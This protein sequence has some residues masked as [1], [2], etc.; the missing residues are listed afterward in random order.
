MDHFLGRN[1]GQ[2]QCRGVLHIVEAGDTLYKIGKKYGVPVSAIMYAN[3]YVNIYNLQIG[4]EICVPV[5]V[6][7]MPAAQA[8]ESFENYLR[9]NTQPVRDSDSRRYNIPTQEE[10]DGASMEPMEQMPR[11]CMN[12]GTCADRMGF[13]SAGTGQDGR[14]EPF[15]DNRDYMGNFMSDMQPGGMQEA[16]EQPDGAALRNPQD[17]MEE[18][19]DSPAQEPNRQTDMNFL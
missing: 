14:E 12:G 16:Y 5:Y 7:R 4:D 6:P 11:N 18:A 2:M 15:S 13:S 9:G 3:P 1:D 17:M 10:N 19:Q 8:K